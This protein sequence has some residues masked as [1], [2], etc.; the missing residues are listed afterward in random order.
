ME[1]QRNKAIRLARSSGTITAREAG[2]AGVHSQV[3][4]RLVAEG[5]LERFAP[6]RYR[7]VDQEITTR[8][9]LVLAAA[10]APKGVLCLL[11]ALD[12]HGIGTQLPAE[13]WLAVPRGTRSPSLQH[14][15]VRLFRFS[16]RAYAYGIEGHL[17]EGTTVLVYSVAK[18]LADLFK[19]RNRVGIDVAVEALREAWQE[20]KFQMTE[21]D[22]AA[23]ACRVATVLRPYIEGI[24]G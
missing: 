15:P 9:G 24:V 12:F 17:I 1:L 22:E 14:P 7:L 23:Q 3:L 4:T 8:H 10:A 21:L 13:I 11:S 2:Q 18:T 6:G 16:G 5:V 19:Y 20:R